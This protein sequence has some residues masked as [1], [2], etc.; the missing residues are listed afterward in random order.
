MR[1]Y[2]FIWLGIAACF[3]FM[4][5]ENSLLAAVSLMV[6]WVVALLL[7]PVAQPNLFSSMYRVEKL[8]STKPVIRPSVKNA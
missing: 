7:K 5:F 4:Q 6:S 3:T 2:L 1:H 8:A